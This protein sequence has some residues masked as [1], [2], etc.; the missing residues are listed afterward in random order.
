MSRATAVSASGRSSFVADGGNHVL[1]RCPNCGGAAE[2]RESDDEEWPVLLEHKA[3]TCP[4]GRVIYHETREAAVGMWMSHLREKWP[5]RFPEA[6]APKAPKARRSSAPRFDALLAL[7]VDERRV[8]LREWMA[9]MGL[10]N[11]N[12]AAPLLALTRQ[13]VERMLYDGNHRRTAVTN[14]TLR[15]AQLCEMVGSKREH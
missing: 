13:S 10:E 12:Q 2:W 4:F 6:K 11:A 14:Q 9:R 7:G 1:P 5:R 3:A 15:I 8:W